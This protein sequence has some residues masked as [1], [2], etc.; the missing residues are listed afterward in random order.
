MSSLISTVLFANVNL[1]VGALEHSPEVLLKSA[2]GDTVYREHVMST[3]LSAGWSSARTALKLPLGAR[4]K[5]DSGII[6]RGDTSRANVTGGPVET[7]K[8]IHLCLKLA[9]HILKTKLRSTICKN[10]TWT[11]STI[12]LA[13]TSFPGSSPC[14]PLSR[15]RGPWDQ[16]NEVVLAIAGFQCQ[17][18]Q[19]RSK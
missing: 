11:G 13:T 3:V 5:P 1:S 10:L 8:K 18:I 17:A 16:G 14:P 9:S 19:N 15:S 7:K 4:I 6:R 12:L 2:S